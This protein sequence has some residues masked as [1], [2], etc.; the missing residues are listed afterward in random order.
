MRIQ[1]RLSI[2]ASQT[3]V[4]A[5]V[6]QTERLAACLPGCQRVVT[7]EPGKAYQAYMADQFGPF[8]VEAVM[9]VTVEESHAPDRIRLHAEGKDNRL[10]A[11]QIIDLT[12]DLS[13]PSESETILD[14]TGDFEVLGKVASLGQFAIKRKANDVVK[15]FG[16][17]IR[18]A[19][20]AASGVRDA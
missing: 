15:R 13:S 1:E 17:N 16:P 4:W 18:A 6:W 5:F 7:L 3:H 11:T 2:P 10:G 19:C 12:L 14:V 8:R 9:A 20:T